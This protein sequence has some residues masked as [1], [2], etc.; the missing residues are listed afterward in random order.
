MVRRIRKVNGFR[1]GLE[2][3]LALQLERSG[4]VFEYEPRDKQVAYSK[5]ER[6]S[7]YLPDFVLPNGVII[8]GKGRFLTDDRAKFLLIKQQVQD[9]DIRFV[10]SRSATPI[11]KGSKTTYADWCRKH[12][13]LYADRNIPQEWIDEIGQ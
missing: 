8:E 9:V 1:S 13:F 5:P 10:F 11:Y 12:G 2:N 4:V 7:K 6:E 3:T